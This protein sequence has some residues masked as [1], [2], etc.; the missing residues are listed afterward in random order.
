MELIPSVFLLLSLF[1]NFPIHLRAS[2]A[3]Q[4]PAETH[5]LH[6]IQIKCTRMHLFGKVRDIL[7][8]AEGHAERLQVWDT[9]FVASLYLWAVAGGAIPEMKD[10][11]PKN[12]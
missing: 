4:A 6:R 10:Y 8:L 12:R 11:K 9:C 2:V 1:H 5:L 3:E 7:R